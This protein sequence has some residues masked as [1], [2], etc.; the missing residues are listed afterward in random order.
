MMLAANRPNG[1]HSGE[2]QQQC[3]GAFQKNELTLGGLQQ[4]LQ[5][6]PPHGTFCCDTSL[7]GRE[8]LVFSPCGPPRPFNNENGCSNCVRFADIKGHGNT[9]S[10]PASLLNS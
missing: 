10:I 5:R 3:Q 1:G 9:G 8:A 7:G 4:M 6:T 2:N